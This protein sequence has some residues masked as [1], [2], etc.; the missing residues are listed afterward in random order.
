[1]RRF[2]VLAA[3]SALVPTSDVRA[4]D[5]EA[6]LHPVGGSIGYSMRSG[7]ERCEGLYAADVSAPSLEL[8]GLRAGDGPVDF[9]STTLL[10]VSVPTAVARALQDPVRIRAATLPLASYYRLDAS[11]D[12]RGQ[13]EWPV[14]DVLLPAG[15]GPDRLG[16]VGWIEEEAGRLFLPL[17][18]HTAGSETQGDAAITLLIR[19]SHDVESIVWRLW[20]VGD[21]DPGTDWT[22]AIG[23]SLYAGRTVLLTV[24]EGFAGRV[25]VEI[26]AKLAGQDRWSTL[27]FD[28]LTPTSDE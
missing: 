9:Q 10:V 8:L 13:L 24:P 16:V 25:R 11:I 18:I 3:L 7:D 17:S 1:M 26:A 12:P 22:E 23:S 19:T 14:A 27:N 21:A 4:Q 5:C 2:V 6:S 20:E 15:I 28:L